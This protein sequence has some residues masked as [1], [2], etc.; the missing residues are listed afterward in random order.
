MDFDY[1]SCRV[2]NPL[3]WPQ[4]VT[5]LNEAGQIDHEGFVLEAVS[6]RSLRFTAPQD[7]LFFLDANPVG[8]EHISV[9]CACLGSTMSTH[10][11][12]LE[13]S[14]R[15]SAAETGMRYEKVTS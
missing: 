10:R 4:E 11:L 2:P 1:G 13:G 8:M 5:D 12:V 14:I 15:A 3:G 9:N 7:G 6:P